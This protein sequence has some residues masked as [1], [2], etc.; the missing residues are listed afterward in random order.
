[1]FYTVRLVYVN[2]SRGVT[3]HTPAMSFC[4]CVRLVSEAYEHGIANSSLWIHGGD[5][6]IHPNPALLFLTKAISSFLALAPYLCHY[7]NCGH[8]VDGPET[9]FVPALWCQSEP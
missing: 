6:N 9:A 8:R 3:V 7:N 2:I 5:P 4:P 1:M